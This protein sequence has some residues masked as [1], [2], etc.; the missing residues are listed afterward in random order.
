MPDERLTTLL[1]SMGRKDWITP[2]LEEYFGKRSPE[3]WWGPNPQMHPSASVGD[4]PR[5]IQLALLGH[6][7]AVDGRLSRIFDVGKAMHDR[8]QQYFEECGLLVLK[9][10]P[11]E[12][13]NSTLAI[14][15]RLDCVLKAP[16][17]IH[18]ELHVIE[19]K[20]MS[21]GQFR[22]LP[23]PKSPKENLYAVARLHAR[24]IGQW[25]SYSRA[26]DIMERAKGKTGVQNGAIIFENKDNQ[27]YKIF[28]LTYDEEL[29]QK[30][31]AN[32]RLAQQAFL[33]KKL[34]DA[35]YLRMSKVC[36]RCGRRDLCYRLQDGDKE[37]WANIY[38]R[39]GAGVKRFRQ[40]TSRDSSTVKDASQSSAERADTSNS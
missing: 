1:R 40:N 6:K 28:L 7:T 36:Q 12:T 31:T 24:Y 10:E 34:I 39:L 14:K 13:D 26:Y 32:A 15:G 23:E 21:S 9:E 2:V 27:D 4:C 30:L 37:E 35:P 22:R 25:L 5:D 17:A 8:W 20:S 29:W 18:D 19:L 16:Q 33:E 11:I 3:T 38:R